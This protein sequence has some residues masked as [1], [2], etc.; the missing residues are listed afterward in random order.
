MKLPRTEFHESFSST[1]VKTIVND[2]P[3]ALSHLL[4]KFQKNVVASMCG[5]PKPL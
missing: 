3:S 5:V 2:F 1:P 4:E